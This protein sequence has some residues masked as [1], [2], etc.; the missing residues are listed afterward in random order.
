MSAPGLSY[1]QA[2][3]GVCSLA[4]HA[5]ALGALFLS[6]AEHRQGVSFDEPALITAVVK[7]ER[8]PL[9]S[10][11]PQ[12]APPP[13]DQPRR[14]LQRHAPRTPIV[15]APPPPL[16]AAPAV[17]AAPPRPEPTL[18]QEEEDAYA[19][20]VWTHLAAHR[21]RASGGRRTARVVFALAMDGALRYVRLDRSSGSASFDEACLHA[22]H[23]AAPFPPAPPGASESLRTFVVP[24]ST[25]P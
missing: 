22:V 12:T 7:V 21:P 16:A 5:L 25:E 8:P 23:E 17:A 20:A 4:V 6:L 3:A 24:I 9:R 10:P 11:P 18:T 13:A 1:A 14:T 15:R 19:R 2:I